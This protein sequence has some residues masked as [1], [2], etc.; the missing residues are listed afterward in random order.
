[1]VVFVCAALAHVQQ[2]HLHPTAVSNE[3]DR[4][5]PNADTEVTEESLLFLS[6]MVTL[7]T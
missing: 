6:E 5:K 2:F 4:V 3:P 7:H 1:M